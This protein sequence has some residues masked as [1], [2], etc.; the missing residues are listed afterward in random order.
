MAASDAS[1]AL[2]L[3]PW[4]SLPVVWEWL[5]AKPIRQ[6]EVFKRHQSDSDIAEL[7]RLFP[8]ASII[9]E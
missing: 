3:K 5:G 6:L 2:P 9:V 1:D 4:R 8:D 7:E